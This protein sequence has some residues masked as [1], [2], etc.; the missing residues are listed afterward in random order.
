MRFSNDSINNIPAS[1]LP[2]ALSPNLRNRP[3]T[4]PNPS[5]MDPTPDPSPPIVDTTD[6][7]SLQQRQSSSS[8]D[9][10]YAMT[11]AATTNNDTNDNTD[12]AT[13]E[14]M[15]RIEDL[16][17]ELELERDNNETL[18]QNIEQRE[19]NHTRQ[20]EL[21]NATVQSLRLELNAH[22]TT[23]ATLPSQPHQSPQAHLKSPN[24]PPSLKPPSS[25][26]NNR[27]PPLN[28]PKSPTT[29]PLPP[30]KPPPPTIDPTILAFLQNQQQM[31]NDHMK[32]NNQI[33]ANFGRGIDS[34]TNATKQSAE[35]AVLH[36]KETIKARQIKGPS[37]NRFT[38][39]S[40]KPNESFIDWYDDLLSLLALSEWK[41]IYDHDTHDAHTTTTPSNAHLS[42]HLYSSLRIALTG[43][44]GSTIKSNEHLYR[45]KGLEFL[46]S[47]KPIFHPKWTSTEFS[48]KMSDFYRFV[49]SD[50]MTIDEYTNQFRRQ[51]R[52]LQ[53][54]GV[55]TNPK[56]AAQQ[57][58]NGLG[59][60]FIPIRN[61][62]TLP[63]EFQTTKLDELAAAA[64]DQLRRVHANRNFQKQQKIEQR[65]NQGGQQNSQPQQTPSS[66]AR[67]QPHT[68]T[69][70]PPS[71]T[72]PPPR[73]DQT[74]WQK[75]IMREIG[76]K[77]HSNDRKAYW[78]SLTEPHCCYF[79][80][81]TN[82][83]SANCTRMT[84]AISLSAAG[85][86]PSSTFTPNMKFR[87]ALPQTQPQTIPPPAPSNPTPKPSTPAPTPPTRPSPT[88]RRVLRSNAEDSDSNSTSNDVA[89]INDYNYDADYYP[90]S[91]SSCLIHNYVSSTHPTTSTFVVDSGATD[92]MCNNRKFFSALHMQTSINRFVR[93][94]DGKQKI[95]IHGVGKIQYEVN[96]KVIVLHNVLYV[97]DLDVSLYSVKQHMR[98]QGCYEHSE[99]DICTIAYPSH[100]F[101]ATI[102]HEITFIATV[103]ILPH[104]KPVFDNST[105]QLNVKPPKIPYT[106][107]PTP[108]TTSTVKI[109]STMKTKPVQFVPSKSTEQS[110][111]YDLRSN[112]NTSIPPHSRKAVGLG[113]SI[114]I[115]PGLYGRIAP[116]S[117]LALKHNVDVAAGVIDPDYRGE[118]KV[119][120]VNSSQRKFEI[121]KG[122]K[123][124]QLIF[125]KAASPAF[126]LLRTLDKTSRGSGGFGSTDA[127]A[128]RISASP[129]PSFHLNHSPTP[130]PETIS[131]APT[132]AQTSKSHQAAPNATPPVPA[133]PMQK[134]TIP[135]PKI[136]A[137]LAIN[138]PPI[139]PL[140]KAQDV[141]PASKT[142]TIEEL[143]K[144]L[145][146]RQ[147]DKVMEHMI[148]TCFQNNF[149]VSTIDREPTLELGEVATIDK[150]RIP[151]NPVQLP[152][153]FGDAMHVDI[154]YGCN[155]G[156]AGVKYALFIVDRAT[157]YKYVYPIKSLSDDIL[158]AFQSLVKDMGFA[159]KKL[160]TD[161]DRKLF[162]SNVTK[163][164][165]P[166]GTTIESAPPRMQHKNGLVERNWRSIVRMARSWLTSALLPSQFWFHA[167]SRAVETSNYLPVTMNGIPTTPFELVHHHK[168]DLRALIPLFS[169]AY[170][171]HPNTGTTA[172]PS[173]SSQTLRVILIGKSTHSTALEFYHPPT[174]QIYS[175][176]VYKLDP[177][178]AAGP[179][180]DLHYDGGLF[181]NTYHNEAEQS[182]VP[183]YTIDQNIYFQP[184]THD[185]TPTYTQGKILG[186]PLDNTDIYTI[187]RLDN[188]NIIQMPS[189]RLHPSN[190]IV[191]P[192]NSLQVVDK[193][194]PSW[195]KQNA[196]ATL[197]LSTMPKPRR[198]LLKRHQDNNW[199][200]HFG[201][202]NRTEPVLLENFHRD[203]LQLIQQNFLIR[204]HPTFSKIIHER[205]SST[206]KES[207]AR[208]VSAAN[209]KS[210]DIPTLLQ[211]QSLEKNDKD[212]WKAAYDE[213]YYG[214]E[215]LPAWT[216]I[217]ET[218]YKKIKPTVG[219]LLPTMAISTIKYDE[220]GKPK[221]CK[222]RIVALGNLD[223][224]EWSNNDCY[225]PVLSTMEVRLLTSL[226]IFHKRSLKNGDI[227]Q[228]FCQAVLPPDEPYVLRPPPGCPNTPT[229]TY[230]LLKRTLYGLKRS[231]RH[232]FTKATQ[233]LAQ[234]GLHPTPN[235]PCLFSGKP[236]GKNIM[237]L[238]LYVDDLCYFSPSDEC[239]R[240][241]EEKLNSLT[242]VD[243]MGEVNHF[244]GLKFEWQR[245][246]D[247]HIDAF[248]SQT[249]FAEQL[250]ENTKLSD[251]NPSRTPY[252]SGHPVDSV[253]ESHLTPAERL[254]LS[255]ELRSMT[256]SLLWLA[257]G[258][259]PDLSTIVSMLAQYQSN[260]SYGH[261]RA[262]KHAIRYVLGTKDLGITFSSKENKN[263][264]AFMNF[265]VPHNSLFPLTDANW[266]G[267][268]QG[269]N[270]T[271]ITELDRFKSRSM[272]GFIIYFNGPVHWC[273]KRQ[274]ITARSSAEAE[275][276]ATD[277][278]VKE[279]L[280]IKHMSHDLHIDHILFP[281][282]PVNV[283]NDNNACVCWSKAKTTK[284]LRHI[285]IRENAIR[286]SV[287]NDFIRV[288]HIEGKLNIADIFTKE[289]KDSQHFITM[290]DQLVSK[291]QRIISE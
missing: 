194:L 172:T 146:Y 264:Q 218:E 254:K 11:S 118:V 70:I 189:S 43:A 148:N 12:N 127:V 97:P 244:L 159:P 91:S 90:R 19:H 274:K 99:N 227:K 239:E 178:L 152:R 126:Q 116:R 186:L 271:S 223:P 124:A 112:V 113:F 247:G 111:G 60:E 135:T 291:R 92:H 145:G 215:K 28:A 216:H 114:A 265:P 109:A 147:T 108:T 45:N 273:S 53:Y 103:P 225:A 243:F 93:L 79:H 250:I 195:I 157:R 42:E 1:S 77:V 52:E 237:Y 47:L 10:D 166:L 100:T 67:V 226:A 162:G 288:L 240:A 236:D 211:M 246:N 203:G 231:P 277:E 107:I 258:T 137:P 221:R 51:I 180:F 210:L 68:R 15:N 75:E 259:R 22:K 238:G 6:M 131:T 242:T 249:A 138:P 98:Y 182:I 252:R 125:E 241:F 275:L 209:L 174:K 2:P 188:M 123:V 89:N 128:K 190:P 170:I 286:E 192:T 32:Q 30:T 187:Q 279:L 74:D 169:I 156:L 50:Q 234:C 57:Y 179:V 129:R 84:R 130:S 140:D 197:F 283:Y 219:N 245:H 151:T 173:M 25:N 76:F 39:F 160:I 235:N 144:L 220:N 224:H 58:I 94:G 229:N 95:P 117:G 23:T 36:T 212:L 83:N 82:H 185:T 232:W 207:V 46:H 16:A 262:A 289:I 5:I 214:L 119:L 13:T 168:P 165:T 198:G 102:D 133:V 54:N 282:P 78:Q 34:L 155:C 176:S 280:R 150:T 202:T 153:N 276:Y 134:P 248:L 86:T 104:N 205:K 65:Q 206:F 110:I 228:A 132:N 256:G 85:T 143:R 257:N 80:R 33:L 18:H 163:Y 175:S 217:T 141:S 14:L 139:R 167:I 8:D 27:A 261:I 158:P 177:T 56:T 59:S 26:A 72:I 48:T 136:K 196:P 96:N 73:P 171:D 233:L 64:R 9:D 122:D 24:P 213:E 62:A 115:P 37:A 287:D 270:R 21:L 40:N 88:L 260:P 201:R 193:A 61:M 284:G 35:A 3:N 4:R 184:K 41:G 106:F 278:C 269:H 267:Q 161:F 101:E 204:G 164:F 49:R 105:A 281:G 253:A 222:W 154:G 285:T 121:N 63:Q 266:G 268:D 200:F 66:S 208:H 7:P 142:F 183:T 69:N 120:L 55:T 81:S 230:W 272:S 17:N 263:M 38:K 290:R 149:H 255:S 251:A 31:M 181:F 29:K 199:Y 44:A 20:L 191:S 71:N 87:Q